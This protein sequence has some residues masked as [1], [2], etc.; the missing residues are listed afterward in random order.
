[1][2]FSSWLVCSAKIYMLLSFNLNPATN[3]SGGQP[4]TLEYTPV[5][6]VKNKAWAE[7]VKTTLNSW[8]MTISR[9]NVVCGWM[10]YS[11]LNIVLMALMKKEKDYES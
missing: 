2:T 4:Q 1:M 8:N 5:Y 7:A 11:A 6:V 10:K 3:Y 9:L